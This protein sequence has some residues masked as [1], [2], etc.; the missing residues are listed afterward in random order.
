MNRKKLILLWSC[1]ETMLL[2]MLVTLVLN[3]AIGMMAFIASALFV[4]IVSSAGLLVILR[5][6]TE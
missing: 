1:L 3:H 6:Y 4:S 2:V 5:K